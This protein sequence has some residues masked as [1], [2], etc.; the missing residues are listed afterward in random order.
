ME[1]LVLTDFHY[2]GAGTRSTIPTRRGDLVPALLGRLREC[3][4]GLDAMAVLGDVIEN[5]FHPAA[6]DDLC[7][8]RNALAQFGVPVIAVPGNHDRDPALFAWIFGKAEPV[9]VGSVRFLPFADSYDASD[10][11]ARDLAAMERMLSTIR[12]GETVIACQHNAILPKIE[13][14]Y[15]YTPPQYLEIARA[16]RE[17][18]VALSLSGHFHSGIPLLTDGGVRHLCVPALCE[19]PFQYVRLSIAGER[20]DVRYGALA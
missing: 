10:V 15:P 3:E 11:C 4:R 20:I 18:G 19:T 14:T 1:L 6:A 9:T 5:G 13:R 12:E 16:Y 7:G 17:A 2:A 8:M